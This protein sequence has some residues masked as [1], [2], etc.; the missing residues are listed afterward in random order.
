M[1]LLG[2]M[3]ISLVPHVMQAIKNALMALKQQGMSCDLLFNQFIKAL[4][5]AFII[6]GGRAM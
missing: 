6:A 5:N 1:T 4:S 3:A 2:A